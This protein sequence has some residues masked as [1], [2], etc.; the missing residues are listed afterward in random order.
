MAEIRLTTNGL[1][2][3]K[4]TAI[5]IFNP[6]HPHHPRVIALLHKVKE[7]LDS[8]SWDPTERRRVGIELVMTETPDGFPGDATN[9][10][11]GVADVLQSNRVN[12]DLSHLGELDKTSLYLDDNQI[13]EVRYSVE[14]GATLR[15]RVRVWVL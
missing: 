2:P 5:S 8:S 9:Y 1:P 6:S 15:Y 7:A 13:R 10:L 4:N 3:A 12:A 14:R 11:G